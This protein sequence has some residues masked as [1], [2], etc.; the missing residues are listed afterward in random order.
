MEVVDDGRQV[1]RPSISGSGRQVWEDSDDQRAA[2]P[3]AVV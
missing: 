1:P 2:N 3:A